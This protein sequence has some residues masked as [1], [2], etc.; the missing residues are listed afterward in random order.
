MPSLQ[1]LIEDARD[2]RVPV[3]GKPLEQCAEDE[4][5]VLT[6][7]PSRVNDES[8]KE[9]ETLRGT[10]QTTLL[11]AR[12]VRTV[13]VGWNV[14]RPRRDERGEV[15]V[16]GDGQPVLEPEPITEEALLSLGL[17]RLMAWN[18]AITQDM[19]PDPTTAGASAS[20]SSPGA[21]ANG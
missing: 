14:T 21:P 12:A 5:V 7:R 4:V 1:A 9:T 20:G 10:G 13:L 8:N 6:Y 3:N 19:W 16:D 18:A 15:V 2:V 17:K 11:F